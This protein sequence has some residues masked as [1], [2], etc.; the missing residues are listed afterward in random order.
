MAKKK[1]PL[2]KAAKVLAVVMLSL[3]IFRQLLEIIL[4]LVN[5]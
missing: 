1:K 5:N 3:E 2:V 4:C